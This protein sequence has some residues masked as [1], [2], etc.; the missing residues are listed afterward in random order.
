MAIDFPSAPTNG[1]TVTVGSSTFTYNAAKGTWDLT[2]TT[3]IGPTGPTGP[4]GTAGAIGVDGVFTVAATTPPSSP[5]TGATWFNSE[6]GST[7]VYYDSFW[8]QVESAGPVGATGPAGA[9]VTQATAPGAP[10]TGQ[11]WLNTEDGRLYIYSGS[12]WFEPTNNLAGP[13]GANGTSGVISVTG[14]I[15][16]TGTSTAAIIG[17]NSTVVLTDTTQ[18][19][20]NK[21][22]SGIADIPALNSR[23]ALSIGYVGLPQY[24]TIAGIPATDLWRVFAGNHIYTTSTGRTHTI[25]ANSSQALE[26][27][28]TIVFINPAGVTTTIAINTDTLL[29][30]GVGTTGSRTLAPFGMATCVKIAATTW[31]IS[32]NGLT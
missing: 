20:T 31:I 6:T 26:I 4:T 2:T 11:A 5:S 25:P 24:S 10:T 1:Q 19:L 13:A 9:Y 3:V 30:A 7:Y 27:G 16:N 29:L 12:V 23:A 22:I 32:G 14:P 21:T 17:V 18:T 15:T 28:T 8:V